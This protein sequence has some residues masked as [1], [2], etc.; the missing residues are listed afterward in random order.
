MATF[1]LFLQA[2]SRIG[3]FSSL[4]CDN[5]ADLQYIKLMKV[6]ELPKNKALLDF[7]TLT[8]NHTNSPEIR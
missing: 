5:Q 4:H 8:L 2:G 7:L 1:L 3:F 6:W